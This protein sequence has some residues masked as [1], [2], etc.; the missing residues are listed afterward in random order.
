M[1]RVTRYNIVQNSEERDIQKGKKSHLN[2]EI[3]SPEIN[4]DFYLAMQ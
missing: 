1:A 3:L 4:L 2:L